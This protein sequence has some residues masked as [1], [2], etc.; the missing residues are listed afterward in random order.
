[1][2]KISL[3]SLLIISLLG[4]NHIVTAQE[5]PDSFTTSESENI[6]KLL[7]TKKNLTQNHKIE[8]RY[9]IQLYSGNMTVANS[10]MKDFTNNFEFEA[11]LKYESPDYKVWVG[12]FRNRIE[13]DRALLKIKE[14]YP[15]AF[16]P[17]PTRK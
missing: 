6:S 13:A 7:E 3:K 11:R 16:I 14:L 2:K 10:K 15:A 9:S 12:Y 5:N 1:M 8:D 17:K 4:I